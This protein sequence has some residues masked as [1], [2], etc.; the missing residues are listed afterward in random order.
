[1]VN[2]VAYLARYGTPNPNTDLIRRLSA[3]G[4][5]AMVCGQALVASGFAPQ[6]VLEPLKVALSAMT[7]I[8]SYRLQGYV[9]MP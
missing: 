3:L 5:D 8:A 7:A 2:D 9:V 4:V 1:M 6:V